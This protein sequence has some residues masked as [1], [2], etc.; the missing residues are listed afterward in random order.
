[1]FGPVV[2]TCYEIEFEAK[3]M[4]WEI[5]SYVT[6]ANGRRIR[7]WVAERATQPDAYAVLNRMRNLK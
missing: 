2:D 1:M 7:N 4:M 6:Y 5:V 3:S